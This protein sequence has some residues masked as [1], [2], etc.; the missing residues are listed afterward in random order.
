M[1]VLRVLAVLASRL[2]MHIKKCRPP[3]IRLMA[4]T[5]RPLS[6]YSPFV[7]VPNTL[8]YLATMPKISPPY[9]RRCRHTLLLAPVY[10]PQ[11][12]YNG[13]FLPLPVP[14]LN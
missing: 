11:T 8:D 7:L 6:I 14:R 3:M 13:Y 9:C 5:I 12:I 1:R 10:P 4:L 2:W